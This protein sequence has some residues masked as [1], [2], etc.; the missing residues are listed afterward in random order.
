MDLFLA[1]L[2]QM[3]FLFTFIIIGYILAKLKFIPDGAPGI[4]SKLENYVIVPSLII[5]TFMKYCTVASLKEQYRMVLYCLGAVII[6]VILAYLMAGFFEKDAF[7]AS[8]FTHF[9]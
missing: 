6:A 1:T 2:N 3:A 4:L 9:L 7:F 8:F 5:N